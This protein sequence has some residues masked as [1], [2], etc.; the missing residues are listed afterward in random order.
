MEKTVR[1]VNQSQLVKT[2]KIKNLWKRQ[3]EL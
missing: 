3:L 1:I 2:L